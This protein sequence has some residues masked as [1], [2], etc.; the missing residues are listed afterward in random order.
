MASIL[1]MALAGV[2]AGCAKEEKSSIEV[3]TG[4]KEHK[5]EWTETDK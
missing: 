1:G 2:F 3:D 5:I 4:E